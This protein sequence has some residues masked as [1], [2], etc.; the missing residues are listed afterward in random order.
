MNNTLIN[1]FKIYQSYIYNV[2]LYN[3]YKQEYDKCLYKIS[4]K[5]FLYKHI[6]NQS[7]VLLQR[8]LDDVNYYLSLILNKLFNN[9]IEIKISSTHQLK[10]NS[11][12]FQISFDVIYK[13]NKIS[14]L[15]R[16]SGGE[17]NIVSLALL[18]SFSKLNCSKILMIDE[19]MASLDNEMREKCLNVI[20]EWTV[21]KF[22][23]N[24]C[25]ELSNI[26]QDNIIEL[27][28]E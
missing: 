7:K 28:I 14:K 21:D 1:K 15:E 9:D 16:L 11:E 19:V 5:E 8:K 18:L 17:E 13:G 4:Q 12:K 3:Q 24:V 10:D 2:N 25:H 26:Y 27:K 22:V 20:K 23:I 6:E